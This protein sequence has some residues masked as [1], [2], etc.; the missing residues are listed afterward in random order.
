MLIIEPVS[1]TADGR[2]HPKQPCVHLP[3]SAA[4][5]RKIVDVIHGEGRL[6]GINLNHAGASE[7]VTDAVLKM[8]IIGDARKA[9]D[10]FSAVHAGYSLA[11]KY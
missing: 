4:G 6:A 5:L 2:E 10:I 7:E 3:E 8:K 11:L 9:Q 1:V